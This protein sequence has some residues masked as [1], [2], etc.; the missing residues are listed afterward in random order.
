M[1]QYILFFLSSVFFFFVG[2]GTSSSFEQQEDDA[3]L[4]TVPHAQASIPMLGILINYNNQQISSNETTWSN[5]LFGKN[6]HQLNHY[7]LEVSAMHFEFSKVSENYGIVN[8]SIISVYLDKDHPNSS[9]LSLTYPDLNAALIV[10]D[11]YID[12]SQY[13]NNSDGKITPNELLL[14]FIIA[15]F[16]DAYEASHVTNGVW[17]HQ[18]CMTSNTNSPTLDGVSLMGCQNG[19]NFALFGERH[20]IS[21]PHDATIGIIAHEL[22]HAT[23]GLPD[24][25]NTANVNSGGVGYFGLMGSGTWARQNSVEFA[26]NTPVHF[27]AWS[28]IYNG[29]LN[30]TSSTGNVTLYASSSSSYNVVK[31]PINATS[32]Y[33]LENRGNSGY[34]KGLYSLSGNF[35]GGMALWKID[36]TKLTTQHFED[37]N[38]NADTQNK[39]VDLVE[40]QASN[41]DSSGAGGDEDALYYEGNKNSFSTLITNISQRGSSMSLNIN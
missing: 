18:Y 10:A 21:H 15:G 7:Y 14:T 34:D 38:V 41:I 16:E 29:W 5:K 2:C 30:A 26:G 24:L 19:G 32:Y 27:T 40:A 25:Y 33:L 31:I 35:D 37:N 22:G 9:N 1:H 39:G 12:F 13:D 4:A 28:K 20:D 23:F 3:S 36:K 11:D 17:A 6:E 8:D